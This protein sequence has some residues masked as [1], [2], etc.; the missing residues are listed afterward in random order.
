MKTLKYTGELS[1]SEFRDGTAL[2]LLHVGCLMLCTLNP[3]QALDKQKMDSVLC[4]L[5]RPLKIRFFERSRS[6]FVDFLSV[7]VCSTS[8]LKLSPT[9]KSQLKSFKNSLLVC[10]FLGRGDK[11][12]I[13]LDFFL[14][15]IFFFFHTK[16]VR[17]PNV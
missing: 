10:L 15:S 17:S 4:K 12:R 14:S 7:S 5:G 9:E 1:T 2:A 3:V 6:K 16:S 8:I 13:R 11:Y